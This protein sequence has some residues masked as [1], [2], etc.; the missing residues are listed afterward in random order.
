MDQQTRP[1]VAFAPARASLATPAVIAISVR[2]VL[3]RRV[4]T[5][6]GPHGP[7]GPAGSDD[8]GCR[9]AVVPARMARAAPSGV[10]P[11]PSLRSGRPRSMD[12][13]LGRRRAVFE[14]IE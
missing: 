7:A 14:E 12:L 8:Q 4:R 1:T 9:R 2:P 5:L 6:S 13:G 10:R 11:P 3:M